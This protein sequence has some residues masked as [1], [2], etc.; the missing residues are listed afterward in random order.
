MLFS[1]CPKILQMSA[2]FTVTIRAS[3]HLCPQHMRL[4]VPRG[5]RSDHRIRK[6]RYP[7]SK[8][9]Y[10]LELKNIFSMRKNLGLKVFRERTVAS[11]A[12]IH[13]LKHLLKGFSEQT[14]GH[15]INSE[16]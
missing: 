13:R 4:H 15:I 11:L 7:I 9:Q 3:N 14:E 6:A 16:K 12:A 1:S 5:W 2:I 10:F 8:Q